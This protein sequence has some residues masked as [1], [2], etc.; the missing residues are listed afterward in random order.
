MSFLTNESGC[1]GV[2][3][4]TMNKAKSAEMD[5]KAHI[6]STEILAA[7]NLILA[8]SLFA[9]AP[10]MCRLLR[11]LVE[12]AISAESYDINEYTIGIEVFDRT[13]SSYSTTEDPIV[14]V[15]IGRLREKLKTYYSVQGAATDIEIAIPPGSYTPVIRR[16]HTAYHSATPSH[17]LG[18]RQIKCFAKCDGSEPFTQGLSEEL[19]HQLFKEL[20]GIIVA[21]PSLSCD[22][23]ADQDASS[24]MPAPPAEKHLL[25]GSIRIDSERIRASIRLIDASLGCVAWSEQFD[26]NIFLAIRQQE[27]LAS[28]ICG[29]LKRF[30]CRA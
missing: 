4:E 6:P 29:E 17:T 19:V 5:D 1:P 22:A 10:R 26:R 21:P 20:G 28:S 24:G 12:K 25:E 2:Y 23:L 3:I 9:N 13:P 18:I 8:S 27:E 30:F 7:C 15:Q 16:A 14:R 11:F